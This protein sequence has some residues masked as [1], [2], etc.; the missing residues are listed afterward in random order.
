MTHK[1]PKHVTDFEQIYNRIDALL[2]TK[3]PVIITLSGPS[4]SG[5]TSVLNRFRDRY[6][7]LCTA[8]STDDYYIGKTAMS[9]RMPEGHSDNFDHPAAIDISRLAQDLKKLRNGHEISKPIY[10]MLVSEPAARS[11]TIKPNSIIIVE[12]LVANFPEIRDQSDV[13]ISLDVPTEERLKRRISRDVTRK[14]QT[15]D[16][17]RD[18]F[19]NHIEPNYQTYFAAHDMAVDYIV[20]ESIKLN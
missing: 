10:D 16:Q 7:D 2:K 12:G 15:P 18:L 9:I 20:N 3:T 19:L 1:N 8:I 4:A 17:I 5:K 11:E 6:S 14:G 13:S